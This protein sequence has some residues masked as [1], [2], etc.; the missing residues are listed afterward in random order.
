MP[1]ICRFAGIVIR[2][3][4]RDHPPPHFHAFYAKHEAKYDLDG[5]LLGGRLP[6][7]QHRLVRG[8]ASARR[9]ELLGCWARAQS[10]ESIGSIDPPEV[11]R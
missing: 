3:Y 9:A 5:R 7:R 1:A 10:A 8:W 4:F 11:N 6:R 2:M